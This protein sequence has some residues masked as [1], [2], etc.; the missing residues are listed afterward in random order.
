MTLDQCDRWK[1][2]VKSRGAGELFLAGP[3]SLPALRIATGVITLAFLCGCIRRGCSSCCQSLKND[4]KE[5]R[6]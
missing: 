2:A 6:K 3:L 4:G 1:A 5:I